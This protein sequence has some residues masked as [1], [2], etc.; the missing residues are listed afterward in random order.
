MNGEEARIF[1]LISQHSSKKQESDNG[2]VGVA[3]N[4]QRFEPHTSMIQILIPAVISTYS[5]FSAIDFWVI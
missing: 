3:D 5:V 1:K 2:S 4:R